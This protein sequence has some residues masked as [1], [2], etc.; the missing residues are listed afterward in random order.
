MRITAL[1]LVARTCTSSAALITGGTV[2][3]R[4]VVTTCTGTYTGLSGLHYIGTGY[5]L[6]GGDDVIVAI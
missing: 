2:D 1:A 6:A 4:G 3:S 5:A